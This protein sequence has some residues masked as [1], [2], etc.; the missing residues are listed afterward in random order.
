MKN[1]TIAGLQIPQKDRGEVAK[2]ILE[3]L[4][5]A[6]KLLFSRS[7]YSGMRISRE[8]ALLLAMQVAL[9]EGSWEK[10]HKDDGFAAATN[11]SDW[12]FGEVL[13]WGDMLFDCGFAS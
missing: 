6:E 8:A 13:R 2:F 1:A 9:Y 5:R 7:K 10:Y 3:D 12:F 4:Y 11:Q